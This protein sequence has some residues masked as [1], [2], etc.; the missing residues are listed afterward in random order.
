MWLCDSE[1]QASSLMALTCELLAGGEAFKVLFQDSG[2]SLLHHPSELVRTDRQG[3]NSGDAIADDTDLG[4]EL[5]RRKER[6]RLGFRMA[7][8]SAAEIRIVT[9]RPPYQRPSW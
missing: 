9:K 8:V 3:S 5:Y 1:F 2:W 6:L 4:G 7:H